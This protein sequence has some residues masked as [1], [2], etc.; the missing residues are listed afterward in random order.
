[1]GNTPAVPLV[2]GSMYGGASVSNIRSVTPA[3][4]Q[5]NQQPA[6]MRVSTSFENGEPVSGGPIPKD[7]WVESPAGSTD[8]RSPLR[9]R[10]DGQDLDLTVHLVRQELGFGFRIVGGTEEGSQVG[11]SS[12]LALSLMLQCDS[13][14]L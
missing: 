9:S 6:A 14:N 3:L 4:M 2:P 13:L 11:Q 5:L 10:R 8:S 1:M 7:R 12:M